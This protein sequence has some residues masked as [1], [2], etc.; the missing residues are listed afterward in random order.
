M[1]MKTAI[2][3]VA[4]GKV[5][6]LDLDKIERDFLLINVDKVYYHG[7]E[8]SEVEQIHDEWLATPG[9]QNIHC[10]ADIFDFLQRYS[11]R[12]DRVV[13]YRFM[14]HVR[15]AD[16]SFFIYLLANIM[17]MGGMI[18]CIIPNYQVLARML[19]D[20]DLRNSNW[21][22]HDI[23]LTSEIVNEPDDPHASVWT[24]ERAIHY[25]ELEGRFKVTDIDSTFRFDGREIYMRV[26]AERV[27]TL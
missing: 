27:E 26:F 18:D 23:L 24:P 13:V 14:E 17:E 15:R 22:A 5:L 4:A 25:F 9:Y 8:I 1:R 21:E 3:N 11:K 7:K 12:F 16:L 2:L 19:I 20:E 6:P 10:N